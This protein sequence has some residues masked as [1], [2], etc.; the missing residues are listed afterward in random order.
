MLGFIKKDLL[1]LKTSIKSL[2][3]IVVI[4]TFLAFTNAID[5]SILIPIISVISFMSTFNFDNYNKWDSYAATLPNGRENIVKGKYFATLILIAASTIILGILSLLIGLTNENGPTSQEILL[6]VSV[7]AAISVIYAAIIYPIIFKLGVEKARTV[8]FAV[9]F[10][11]CFSFIF[12][13]KYIPESVVL[14]FI[15][16]FGI[17][18][19]VVTVV[20]FLV[21]YYISK[22][23]YSNKEL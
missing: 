13:L 4:Y 6:E 15:S 23:I 10:V 12:L 22:R 18:L 16:N 2:V 11:L 17:I 5:I 21:S 7:I 3:F 19:P 9:L 14:F 20:T 8:I 1:M